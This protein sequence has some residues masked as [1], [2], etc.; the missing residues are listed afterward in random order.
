MKKFT[1]YKILSLVLMSVLFVTTIN[2][3]SK[4]DSK[5]IEIPEAKETHTVKTSEQNNFA[6]IKTNSLQDFEVLNMNLVINPEKFNIV[7]TTKIEEQETEQ[8]NDEPE[9]KDEMPI[10]EETEVA[11][12]DV[13]EEVIKVETVAAN[14]SNKNVYSENEIYELAKIVMCEAGGESQLCKEY[15]A[16][17]IINRVNSSSFPN[18][19]HGVIFDGYQFSPTFDGSWDYKEPTQECYDAAYKVINAAP[20]T[21]ALYFEA[22]AGESW[23]SRNLTE[24]ASIDNTRFYN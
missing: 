8:I 13:V 23:H 17:V 5:V 11:D 15:V 22:C 1:I 4:Y 7:K 16:Q 24:V 21:T 6:L 2:T 14:T 19:I 3:I 12:T 10:E 20:L 18:T 9:V